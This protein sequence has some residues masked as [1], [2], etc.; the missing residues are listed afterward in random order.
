MNPARSGGTPTVR[1]A[2]SPATDYVRTAR[3]VGVAV[4]RRAGVADEMLDEVRLAIGEA[5]GRA[6]ARHHRHGVADLIQVEM[7]DDGPYTVWVRDS[8][9][10][11]LLGGASPE[12][13]AD[14]DADADRMGATLLAAVVEDLS[15]ETGPDGTQV[16]MT[17]PVRRRLADSRR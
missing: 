11:D 15:W 1:L 6:V 10:V 7:A 17:W 2:F 14:D 16:R 4:A 12:F 8:C 3:L 13:E 5:C 9:G